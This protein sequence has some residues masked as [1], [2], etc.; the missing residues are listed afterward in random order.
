M[1]TSPH[2]NPRFSAPHAPGHSRGALTT[3]AHLSAAAYRKLHDLLTSGR[4]EIRVAP[5]DR[6]F[7]H[8]KAGVI[9]AADGTKTCFLGS[10]VRS[11]KDAVEELSESW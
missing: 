3:A 8:G 4:V 9:G 11:S 10:R 2:P 6:V 7:I 5:K 1:A